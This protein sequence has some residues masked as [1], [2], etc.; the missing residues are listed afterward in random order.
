MTK[1]ERKIEAIEYDATT[2]ITA[3]AIFPSVEAAIRWCESRKGHK[4]L[5]L[6]TEFGFQLMTEEDVEK[7]S[8]SEWPAKWYEVHGAEEDGQIRYLED[9]DYEEAFEYNNPTERSK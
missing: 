9:E 1:P 4:M 8:T 5:L 3:Q 2:E 6:D 7:L